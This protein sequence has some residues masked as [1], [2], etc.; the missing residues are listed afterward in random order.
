MLIINSMCQDLM[1]LPYVVILPH[2]MQEAERCRNE[3][4]FQKASAE[5]YQRESNLVGS[6]VPLGIQC[7][8]RFLPLEEMLEE[9]YRI[10]HPPLDDLSSLHSCVRSFWLSMASMMTLRRRPIRCDW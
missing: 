8:G 3:S 9:R 6:W 1:I 10:M 2:H 4:T 5:A 7:M